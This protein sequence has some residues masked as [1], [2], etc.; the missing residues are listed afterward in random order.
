MRLRLGLF[1]LGLAGLLALMG[2]AAPQ[3]VTPGTV[4]WQCKAPSS[5]PPP[6]PAGYC[7]AGNTYPLPVTPTTAPVGAT[8]IAPLPGNAGGQAVFLHGVGTGVNASTT[9]TLANASGKT[10]YICGFSVTATGAT[11]GQVETVVVSGLL[12]GGETYE[13]ASPTGATLVATLQQGYQ[14][15]CVPAS[16]TNVPIV[17]TFGAAGT[18]STAQ[19]AQV[20]GFQL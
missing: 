3:S 14:P 2:P 12:S 5:G 8:V 10:T 15:Y 20:W 7:P 17:V 19:T 9:A 18:G 1:L 16:G 6:T 4:F 13:F 11:T